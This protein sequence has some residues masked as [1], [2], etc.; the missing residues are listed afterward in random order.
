[1][2]KG[3]TVLLRPFTEEDIHQFEAWGRD[4]ERLWGS[5][6]RFQ[7]D[8]IPQLIVA[9]HKTKLLSRESGFFIIENLE[10][11]R[12]VGFVRYSLTQ[13]PDPDIL[14]PDI[15]FV[16]TDP[17]ARGKGY[18]SEAVRLL[19]DYLFAGYPTERISAVTDAENIPAQK[20]LENTG[21]LCEGTLRRASF[22]DGKYCDWKI[23]S[24][25][26]TEHQSP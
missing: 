17:D 8:H 6:Q 11:S 24:I 3:S 19:L 15:G 12:T 16:I 13:F 14:Y 7:L 23:Y 5:Y 4:R 18:A 2:L 10:D 22:R 25:L 20:L 21:F 1:M 9:F 26:R